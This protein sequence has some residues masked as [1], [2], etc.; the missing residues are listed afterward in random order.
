MANRRSDYYYG[1]YGL[2]RGYGP[3][4]QTLHEADESVFEDSRLQRRNGG[5]SDRNAV[6][7]SRLTG[8][9]WWWE[10]DDLHIEE[11]IPVK[12]PGGPQAKYPMDMIHNCEALWD[13][14]KEI[15]GFR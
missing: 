11:L 9:C 8:L 14:P 13:G 2:V 12:T 10:E 1:S 15:A 6:V 4:C 7:V 5:S 3:L